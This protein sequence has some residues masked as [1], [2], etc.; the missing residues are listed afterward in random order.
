MGIDERHLNQN[1]PDQIG[2]GGS[3]AQRIQAPQEKREDN[4]GQQFRIRAAGKGFCIQEKGAVDVEQ[5]GEYRAQFSA[6]A[7][8]EQIHSAAAGEKTQDNQAAQGIQNVQAGDDLQEAGEVIGKAGVEMKH[9]RAIARIE[10]LAPGGEISTRV[11]GCATF[12]QRGRRAAAYPRRPAARPRTAAA[13]SQTAL[14]REPW[15][16]RSREVL[17]AAEAEASVSSR[18]VTCLWPDVHGIPC[19]M[20]CAGISA[21]GAGRRR[22]P[23]RE[24]GAES[25][26]Q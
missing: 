10:S 18:S 25:R 9:R 15:R 23:G 26:L 2:G 24:S 22:R 1:D 7:P 13:G 3:V 16:A 6:A 5:A 17:P 4:K 11:A 19:K 8:D 20:A 21:P 14:K 12:R